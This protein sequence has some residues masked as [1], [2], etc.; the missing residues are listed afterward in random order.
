MVVVDAVNLHLG[1]AKYS[2][3]QIALFLLMY[4]EFLTLMSNWQPSTTL[5]MVFPKCFSL[6]THGKVFPQ[7]ERLGSG[8]GDLR[9]AMSF[10]LHF[11][12]FGSVENFRL[13]ERAYSSHV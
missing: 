12:G 8:L 5:A 10:V 13:W 3:W 2:S 7:R 9:K 6:S 1:L 4:M 11:V